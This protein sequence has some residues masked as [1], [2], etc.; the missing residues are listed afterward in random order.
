MTCSVCLPASPSCELYE[1]VFKSAGFTCHTYQ[2]CSEHKGELNIYG[3]VA[4]LMS[5][6]VGS[7]V[8][9]DYETLGQLMVVL[10]N[11]IQLDTVREQF[12]DMLREKNDQGNS[13]FAS[14][15]VAKIISNTSLRHDW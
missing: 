7:V 3:L 6:P 12:D 11:S 15:V 13:V 8:L 14:C 2:Q 4:D 1:L 9:L 10:S 5:A